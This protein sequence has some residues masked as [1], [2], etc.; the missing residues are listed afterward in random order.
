MISVIIRTKNEEFWIKHC[1]RAVFSQKLTNHKLEVIIVDNKSSDNTLKIVSLFPIA[2]IVNVEEYFPGHSINEG[3]KASNGEFVAILSSHCVPKNDDWLEYLVKD[4]ENNE[5]IAGTYGKQLPVSFSSPQSYRDLYVTFGNEK[6]IQRQDSFFHNANSIIRKKI[7]Q[8]HNFDEKIS[9]IEDRIWA[10]KVLELGYYISYEPKA[11]VYHHHG[12]HNDANLKR[13]SSTLSVIKSIEGVASSELLP[14]SMKPE[15]SDIISI[16]PIS[17]ELDDPLHKKSFLD[18]INK[19]ISSGFIKDIFVVTNNK[20]FNYKNDKFKVLKKKYTSENSN[21]S[22]I[23]EILHA[24]DQINSDGRYPDYVFYANYDYFFRPPDLIKILIQ[25]ICYK[26][27]NSV[28]VVAEEFKNIWKYDETYEVYTK[29]IDDLRTRDKR[30]PIYKSL[31][32]LGVITRPEVIKKGKLVADDNVGVIINNDTK[33]SL[34]L[35]N[36]FEY[37]LIKKLDT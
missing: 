3:I 17:N 24:L 23:D 35:S 5:K 28:F 19:I 11:E 4:M 20:N 26:G 27:K 8:I 31:F 10:K 16:L 2:K 36:P 13:A 14:N 32:G 37:D 6:R 7:W 1:L 9:N 22:L 12:I 21:I 29:A 30:L 18:M 33:M 25:D 15:F 34:R